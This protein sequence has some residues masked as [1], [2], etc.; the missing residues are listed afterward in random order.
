MKDMGD[1]SEEEEK[2]RRLDKSLTVKGTCGGN[3]QRAASE[4]YK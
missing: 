4:M 1:K 3:E 2:K